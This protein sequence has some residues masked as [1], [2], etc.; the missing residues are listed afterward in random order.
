MFLEP[1]SSTPLSSGLRLQAQAVLLVWSSAALLLLFLPKS[2]SL[3]LMG[4]LPGSGAQ[5]PPAA[6]NSVSKLSTGA[7]GAGGASERGLLL[8]FTCQLHVWVSVFPAAC[9]CCSRVISP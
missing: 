2:L 5:A 8:K 7:G 1:V 9:C 4:C 3:I 6:A